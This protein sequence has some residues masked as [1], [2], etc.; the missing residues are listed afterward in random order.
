MTFALISHPSCELHRNDD[1]GFHPESPERLH[2]INDQL[3]A[4]GL[5]WLIRRYDAPPIME[6]DILRVH[7]RAYL[8]YI[9]EHRPKNEEIVN[10]DGDTHLN[11]HTYDAALHAAGAAMMGVD[12]VMQDKHRYVFCATRPPG[13]HAKR[14]NGGGFC[15][16]N[17]VAIALA[18]AM[19][20]YSVQ[21]VA[22]LDFDVHH[23]D[24]TEDIVQHDSRVLFCS[25]F[26][27]PFYPFSGADSTANNVINI[28]LPGGTTP[29]TWREALSARCLPALRAFQPELILISAGFD[30]HRDDEMGE[31]G[32]VEEDYA[33]ITRELCHIAKDSGHQRIVSCL[34]GGYDL[35]S[36]GR[37]VAAHI[38]VMMEFC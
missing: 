35:S 14:G 8:E 25:V 26:Q 33:W 22:C 21:R 32:L 19:K 20:R 2:A 15:V 16:F 9:Q 29:D 27:H 17:N 10:L 24:G 28:P 38:K 5:D 3:I 30:S 23:G 18:Y 34:E 13:H 37:S 4:S 36:L 1:S 12:M 7:D 31:F 11:A 6:S